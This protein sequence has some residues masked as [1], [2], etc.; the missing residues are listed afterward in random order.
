MIPPA[1]LDLVEEIQRMRA[2]AHANGHVAKTLV[3]STE[4][5]LVLMVLRG[6]AEIPVHHAEGA[7]TV[8]ALDGHLQ[9]VVEDVRYDLVPGQLLVLEPELPH[10]VS[11]IEDSAILLSIAWRGHG[12][13]A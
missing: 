13:A 4:L 2:S 8:H 10:A 3:R 9:I 12:A 5:R 11:A 7:L 6:G 1:R